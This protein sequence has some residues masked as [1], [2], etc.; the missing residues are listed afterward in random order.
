[1]DEKGSGKLESLL[2]VFRMAMRR[3]LNCKEMVHRVLRQYGLSVTMEEF[4]E[5]WMTPYVFGGFGAGQRGRLGLEIKSVRDQ[6]SKFRLVVSGISHRPREFVEAALAR[7]EGSVPLPGFSTKLT[8]VKIRADPSMPKLRAD[9][10]AQ[11]TKLKVDWT[12]WDL[13]TYRDA[14]KRKLMLEWKLRK[15][16]EIVPKDLP[17][18][19]GDFKNF[20]ECY[21]FYRRKVTDTISVDTSWT[22]TE[23]FQDITSWANHVWTGICY[24]KIRERKHLGEKRDE[25]LR[26]VHRVVC[27][28]VFRRGLVLVAV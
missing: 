7:A 11:E 1:V 26:L 27:E 2:G 10:F 8:L 23:S 19:F 18:W 22:S 6:K 14:Y 9:K 3:G 25:L 16:I 28:P 5:W 20:D 15:S 12:V 13:E 21:R 24:W 4:S 17:R